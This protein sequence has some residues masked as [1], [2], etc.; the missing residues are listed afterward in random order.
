MIGS[1]LPCG[2][3]RLFAELNG[4]DVVSSEGS[5]DRHGAALVLCPRLR[6]MLVHGV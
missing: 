4:T 2:L 3:W 5:L 1:P 6:R